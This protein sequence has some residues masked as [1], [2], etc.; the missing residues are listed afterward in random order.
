M[1]KAIISCLLDERDTIRKAPEFE[2]WD[3][4]LITD[5]K[6]LNRMGWEVLKV[7]PWEDRTKQ[8]IHY[9]FLSHKYLD[10]YDLV[11]FIDSDVN[12]VQPPPATDMFFLPIQPRS[13]FQQAK[14]LINIDVAQRTVIDR[15]MTFYSL[16]K[17]KMNEFVIHANFFVRSHSNEMNLFFDVWAGQV[18]M[19]TVHE[20][21]SFRYAMQKSGLKSLPIAS[22]EIGSNFFSYDKSRFIS[23]ISNQNKPSVHHITAGRGDKNIGKAINDIVKGLPDQDWV[24]FR[25]IDSF[26]LMHEHFF[27]QCEEIASRDEFDLIGCMTN[28]LNLEGQLYAGVI[29]ENPDVLH[30]KKI[31]IELFNQ[32][33]SSV[34]STYQNIGGLM[35]FF[36]KRLWLSVGGFD[37][38]SIVSSKGN[39]FDHEFCEKAK[40]AKA[41]IGIAKGIYLFHFYRFGSEKPNL[42]NKH[43][44]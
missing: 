8:V 34:V 5:R 31:A 21:L 19:F 14:A 16:S 44:F 13:L 1:R 23:K 42:D 26:P 40:K 12:L 17:I 37:E 15:Q 3:C 11:C 36:P 30:H 38:G 41:K 25:D 18:E 6:L 2:G 4:V 33:G 43:L 29:S 32:H 9:K 10:E 28:R 24:C 35:L 20:E 7:K 22:N 27:K 39:Y